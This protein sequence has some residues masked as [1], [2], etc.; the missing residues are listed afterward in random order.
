MF[1]SYLEESLIGKA[2]REGTLEVRV[3]DL[4]KWSSDKH[5]SVDAKPYGGGMGMVGRVDTVYR[6]VKDLAR[7][8]IEGKKVKPP[9]G[10]SIIFFT[11]RG[12]TFN[13]RMAS[14]FAKKKRL[15]F[16]CGR[17]E[18]MDE[19]VATYIADTKL[20]I[21]EYDLMGGELPSLVV[22]EAVSRLIPGVIQQDNLLKERQSR[23][24]GFIE[25]P[26]YTRPETFSPKK[27][28]EWKV[29]KTLVSGNHKEIEEWRKK[30]GKIIE[31]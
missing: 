8:R 3:H 25:Y 11:P 12:K 19:R 6:A 22:L 13:Q 16:L 21:G 7:I 27:G 15:I 30:R 26:Q 10:T 28:V 31:T 4:R 5:R 18:G 17:Y 23:G 2:V 1:D 24:G 20:S 14:R 9:E 29:P